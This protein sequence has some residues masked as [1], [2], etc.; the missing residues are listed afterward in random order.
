M[1]STRAVTFWRGRS[2]GTR[3]QLPTSAEQ[4][5]QSI[6][7]CRIAGERWSGFTPIHKPDLRERAMAPCASVASLTLDSHDPANHAS[8]VHENRYHSHGAELEDAIHDYL[9]HHNA[10]PKPFVWTKSADVSLKKERRALNALE[11]VKSG[12]QTVRVANTIGHP[13]GDSMPLPRS[14]SPSASTKRCSGHV[15]RTRRN[16]ITRRSAR[17]RRGRRSG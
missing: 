4:L 14:S 6:P 16:S 2:A 12:N 5:P 15:W 10:D 13:A 3:K 8:W 17:E 7:H 1:R 11:A 9:L